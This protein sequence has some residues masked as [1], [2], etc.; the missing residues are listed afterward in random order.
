MNDT[1][2]CRSSLITCVPIFL[3]HTP[4]RL[5]IIPLAFHFYYIVRVEYSIA[6]EP[7]LGS[8]SSGLISSSISYFYLF[9]SYS[10]FSVRSRA[11]SVQVS[12]SF[13]SVIKFISISNTNT[14]LLTTYEKRLVN[15]IYYRYLSHKIYYLLGIRRMC[16]I[17]V[18]MCTIWV[19]V[20]EFLLRFR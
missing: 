11:G 20:P 18:R 5:G 4:R 17:W 7:W 8:P 1:D 10:H 3:S 6:S 16:T 2:E 13:F 15:S 12:Y 19:R 9:F 14:V